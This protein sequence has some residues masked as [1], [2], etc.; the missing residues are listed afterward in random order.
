MR[1]LFVSHYFYPEGNAPATRVHQMTRRWAAAGHSV[2]VITAVPN[3]PTGVV[4]EGYRNRWRQEET[5]DGVHVLR[6]WTFL[7]A[8]A[9]TVLRIVSF[10]SFLMTAAW[11]GLRTTRPDV[12]IATSPQFFCGWAGRVIAGL[13]RLPF[14]LEIRDI[15]PESIV[16]V[17]AMK[18]STLIRFLEWL[19]RRL[20][21]NADH[22]VTVGQGYRDRLVERGVPERKVVV[23]PNG[24]DLPQFTSFANREAL[25]AEFGLGDRFVCAFVGTIGMASGLQVVLRAARSLKAAS[26]DSFRFFL[27]GDGA[28]RKQLESA[29]EA[30]SLSH[31]VFAGRLAKERIPGVIGAVD[32][33]LVHLIDTSLFRSVMPSKLFEAAAMQK[34]IILGVAGEAAAWLESAR[35]GICI[36]PENDTDLLAAM[37][38]LRDDAP[39]REALGKNG[40][41]FVEQH[42]DYELLAARY[43]DVLT[44]VV[45]ENQAR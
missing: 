45:D 29:A 3:V 5:I 7:A 26:D 33:C 35:A 43:T 14:V 20:Y 30:E 19:E 12:V 25:R 38:H 1:I 34:P 8:N 13:R 4:Y 37:R 22:I 31:I 16:A 21:R 27:V 40:R 42:H 15:W 10:L 9:G 23:V 41:A 24:V 39:L 11:A 28:E 2:T 44:Q 17:G 6:V 36:D 18:K 32:A